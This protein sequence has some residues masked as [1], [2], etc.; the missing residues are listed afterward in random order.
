M[1]R[2]WR[3]SRE[4]IQ[5]PLSAKH[6]LR[7]RKLSR[8]KLFLHR[9]AF[10]DVL[11][12]LWQ[13]SKFGFFGKSSIFLSKSY[14]NPKPILDRLSG[15]LWSTKPPPTV[16]TVS[17]KFCDPWCVILVTFPSVYGFRGGF[18]FDYGR[19]GFI[20]VNKT[21]NV[22]KVGTHT[23]NVWGEIVKGVKM[24]WFS[25]ENQQEQNCLPPLKCFQFHFP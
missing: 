13:I 12:A 8:N 18:K 10:G 22:I 23:L 6:S 4:V 24:L 25:L 19:Q 15:R 9:R 21:L 7:T 11:F 20:Y 5:D 16:M 17:E 3:A 1:C 14:T 2:A